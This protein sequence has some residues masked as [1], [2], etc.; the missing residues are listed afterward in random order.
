MYNKGRCSSIQ[1]VRSENPV[2]RWGFLC[3]STSRTI[4]KLLMISRI[5]VPQ[6]EWCNILWGNINKAIAPPQ[7][8]LQCQTT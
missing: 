4:R 5:E 3:T 2:F 1:Y 7:G 8:A 6:S